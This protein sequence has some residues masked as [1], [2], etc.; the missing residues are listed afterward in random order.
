MV[1]TAYEDMGEGELLSVQSNVVELFSHITTEQMAEFQESDNQ[2]GPIL[3]WVKDGKFPSR[4]VLYHVKS[5]ATRKLFY[6]LDRLVLKRGG[7]SSSL[8]QRGHGVSS[9]S[10]TTKATRE[11]TQI[12]PR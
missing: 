8:Y 7:T 6:Q 9:I 5:K 3:Q 10:P 4:S 12:S 2:I 11:G 1:G